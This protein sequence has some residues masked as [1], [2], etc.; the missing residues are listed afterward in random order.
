MKEFT[1]KGGEGTRIDL[2]LSLYEK[3]ISRS[4]FHKGIKSGLVLVNGKKVRPSYK[5]QTNDR[6]TINLI[7]EVNDP[8][9]PV[10]GKIKIIFEDENII[11]VNKPSGIAVHPSE[12]LKEITLVN[13]LLYYMPT[14]KNVGEDPMRPGIVHRLDKDTSGLIVIA[15]NNK[16]FQELKNAWQ[17]GSVS[18]KYIALVWGR[19]PHDEGSINFNIARSKRMGRMTIAKD[20]GKTALT[21]YKVK[22]RFTNATLLEVEIKTG[23]THQIRTHFKGIGHPVVGDPLYRFKKMGKAKAPRLFLHAF[24]LALPSQKSGIMN[25]WRSPLPKEL[26]EFL[27]KLKLITDSR[28][29]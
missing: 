29:K 25:E 3:E 12:G 20:R 13:L 10:K 7:K 21:L 22:K 9:R 8:L 6:I 15:K 18:K 4:T 5:V 26:K 24:Y 27:K 2:W 1:V 19:L 14:L 11:I 28:G 23:R 16:A 17:E